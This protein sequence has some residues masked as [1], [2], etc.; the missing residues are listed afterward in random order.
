MQFDRLPDFDG[1]QSW[2]C[3]PGQISFCVTFD[4]KHPG[5]G[6]RASYQHVTSE[7]P[8]FLDGGYPSKR[9]AI[10]ALQ[11]IARQ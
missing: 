1:V 10:H 3:K 4:K 7:N 5:Y 2:G 8:V 11:N 9:A 6:W